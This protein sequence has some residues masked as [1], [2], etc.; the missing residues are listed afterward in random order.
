[1]KPKRWWSIVAPTLML[2]FSPV[3]GAEATPAASPSK[4]QTEPAELVQ[5]S[6][7]E[8][9]TSKDAGYVAENSLA[10]SR[11]NSKLRDT[12]GSVSVFTKEFLDDLA[13]T[14][15]KQ[16]VEYSV[17]SEVNTESRVAGSGQNAFI[18]AQNLNGNILTRGIAASQGLD[19]FTSIGPGDGYRGGRYD[20]SRGPNSILFGIGA[21]GG[22][23]NQSSKTANTRRDGATVRYGFGSW[24]RSRVEFDTNLVLKKDRLAF[25]VAAV[26]QKNEGWRNFDFQDKKRIFGTLVTRPTPRLTL[27]AMGETGRDFNAIMRSGLDSEEVLAWYDNRAA[28]G[29]DAVTF[30]PTTALPSAAQIALGVTTRSG[31]SGGLNH[32]VTLVENTG[33]FFDAIGTY[34]SGTYNNAAVRA[35][36][37]SA[38]RTG[39]TLRITAPTIYPFFNNAAG[40]GMNR[41]QTLSNHTLTADYRLAH[42]LFLNVGYNYQE[43]NA[44]LN[45]MVNASPVFRGDPN[46]TVGLGGAPNPF[47]GRLYFDGD[48]RRDTHRRTYRETRASLSYALDTKSRWRG[49]HSLVGLASRARDFDTRTNTWLV[50]AGRPFSTDPINVNNRVTV[51]NYLTEGNYDTYRV[52]DWRSVPATIPFGGQ[53]YRTAYA[54]DPSTG[55]TNAGAIQETDSLLGA[56]QSHFFGDRLVATLGYR[57][58]RAK[59]IA[60]GY[61][62]DPI[63]GDVVDADPAKATSN[64]F[65]GRTQTTGLVYHALDSVS[66]LANRSTSVS[67][68]SFNRT[69][70]PDGKLAGAPS[71]EGADYGA[72]FDLFGGRLNAKLVRFTTAEKGATGSFIATA[73]FT[74]RNQ[75]VMEALG[76]ALSGPGLPFTT[77]QWQALATSYTPNVSGALSDSR[78]SGYEARVTANFTRQWRFV[79]NYSYTDSVR[80]NLYNEA[81]AWYGLKTDA[82]A[83]AK[84]GVAQNAAGQ[85][86]IDPT[87]YVAGGTVAKWIELGATRA[88]ASPSTLATSANV[89]VAQELFNLVDEI[90]ASKQDQEKRWGLRPHKLS[91]FTAY[92]F[93]EGWAKGVTVGGGWRWRSAN[94]IGTDLAGK[95]LTGRPLSYVDLMLR[96][97]R[98]FRQLPGTVSFQMNVS[99]AF[100]NSDPVPVRLLTT[101]LAYRLPG[102]RGVPYGRIDVVDPRE[103]RFTTTYSF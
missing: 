102:G 78:S 96:Y 15:L 83:L 63:L 77:A 38:G 89:T 13:I 14:D 20:D 68:P 46:R 7:F 50:L 47:A 100:D 53:T 23:V 67:V 9:S 4:V 95:E 91:L 42:D 80:R 19:Y 86:V 10:G 72:S 99:N 88:T 92:D 90:N 73:S 98:K 85:F 31:A 58:D 5:L 82:G 45:L 40:P 36:D 32:R 3:R 12:P 51:R 66:L 64:R 57:E 94:I 35:P 60:L 52:G 55:G 48:W 29:A 74:N 70:F 87:A 49:R 75:R 22:I 81:F 41:E 65:S 27:T 8:V 44:V 93:K 17:N 71:G 84:Q 61:R 34:L 30:T 2:P 39:G 24:N 43:T 103:V 56:V 21:V 59:L 76:G 1:M 25:L 28:K 6:P 11:I 16:L 26:D 62:N 79:L 33:V 37:G 69:V 97:A 101:D 18:N 54:N